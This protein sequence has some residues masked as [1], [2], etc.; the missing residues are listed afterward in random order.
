MNDIIACID[1][2]PSGGDIYMRLNLQNPVHSLT[3]N[4]YIAFYKLPEY[5]VILKSLIDAPKSFL[6][7]L[8]FRNSLKHILK[9][10]FY[11]VIHKSIFWCCLTLF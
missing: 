6:S 1:Y 9:I 5:Y 11:R 4:L 10:L 2:F 8:Y 7:H 3:E